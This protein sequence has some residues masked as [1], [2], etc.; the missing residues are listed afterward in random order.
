MTSEQKRRYSR[1][2]LLDGMGTE[3][4]ERLINS[5]VLL[6]GAGGL[7]SPNAL[8]LAAAGVGTIG[9]ADGDVVS[10][11]NL[12]RQ[13]IHFTEDVGKQKVESAKEKM[14][15]MN[16]D[17]KVIVYPEYITEDNALALIKDYDFIIDCT[18]SFSSKYLVNDACIMADKPFCAGGV[19]RY[20]TQVMTHVP[21]SACYRC[22]F[23]EPPE[24]ENV[25]TCSTV[26]VLGSAVGMLGTIQATE[27]IKYLT[28]VGTLLTNTLLTFDVLTMQFMRV[29]F[30]RDEHCPVCGEHPTIT[31]LKEYSFQP[32]RK[33]V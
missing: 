5:R 10:L 4:Q 7:G 22:F 29:D 2:I 30:S 3:G 15:K 33:N 21:G 27:A 28:G 11:S 18:D 14:I 20:G 9:I 24:K 17:V 23:P 13:I 19:V 31:E 32:C 6:I 12:Q 25:D 16:P 8:Y 26:G 1:H